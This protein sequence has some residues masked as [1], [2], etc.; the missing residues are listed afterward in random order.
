MLIRPFDTTIPSFKK[1]FFA[2]Q[3]SGYRIRG[4]QGAEILDGISGMWHT[5]LGYG[6]PD[7]IDTITDQYRQLSASSLFSVSHEPAVVYAEALCEAL[8]LAGW[9]VHL[10]N[11]GADA[12]EAAIRFASQAVL[13]EGRI[14]A[15]QALPDGFHGNSFF[16]RS[17]P[18]EPVPQDWGAAECPII[19]VEPIQGVAGVRGQSADICTALAEA[20]RNGAI[21]IADETG[22]GMWRTGPVV[23]AHG[24]GIEPDLMIVSKGLTNGVVPLGAALIGPGIVAR[25]GAQPWEDGRT[26]SGTPLACAVG[27]KV[28]E[29]LL[30]DGASQAR[31]EGALRLGFVARRIAESVGGAVRQFGMVAGIELPLRR[32][33]DVVERAQANGIFIG[34]GVLA[35]FAADGRTLNLAPGYSFSQIDFDE[36]ELKVKISINDLSESLFQ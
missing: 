27:L 25:I 13:G 12:V 17:L 6:H 20:R 34:N 30:A 31:A 32:P 29:L 18:R 7:L 19:V 8:G 9:R 23:A 33:I 11:N 28:L 36:L 3:A 24:L 15:V 5:P 2:V 1:T 14:P 22:S 26:T 4:E 16:L 10:T 35:R 21:L